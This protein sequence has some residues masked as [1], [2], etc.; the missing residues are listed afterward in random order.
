MHQSHGTR[1]DDSDCSFTCCYCCTTN[2]DASCVGKTA[3]AL[4]A[5]FLAL[6]SVSYF[7][8]LGG[9]DGI[10]RL[11]WINLALAVPCVAM[12]AVAL[13]FLI[14]LG[15]LRPKQVLKEKV[16]FY[17]KVRLWFCIYM[18]VVAII[19][20]IVFCVFVRDWVMKNGF[21]Y[22]YLTLT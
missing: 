4:D 14:S 11:T 20:D 8:G 21:K 13:Y 1:Y 10:E 3:F 5:V 12:L 19:I 2:F 15:A 16:D 6:W 18:T 22:I 9:R 7:V 17:L